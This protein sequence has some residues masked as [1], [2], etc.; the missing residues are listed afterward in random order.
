MSPLVAAIIM[1]PDLTSKNGSL[2]RDQFIEEPM[3]YSRLLAALRA[4]FTMMHP[5][6]T[7]G[8]ETAILSS[9]SYRR[10]CLQW[11]TL[12]LQPEARAAVGSWTDTIRGVF[13]QEPM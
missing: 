10:F 11:R 1:V 9:Y 4:I 13:S 2:Q 5:K 3:P 8:T 6:L 12:S 7:T